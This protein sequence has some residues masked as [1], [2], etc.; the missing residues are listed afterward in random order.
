MTKITRT[1]TAKDFIVLAINP[2]SRLMDEVEVTV[3]EPNSKSIN[4]QLNEA[5]GLESNGTYV[6]F[7][8]LSESEPYEVKL[9]I[10]LAAALS[11]GTIEKIKKDE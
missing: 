11:V 3:I 10:D 5:V 1:C 9:T 8:V 2:D 7:Q 6:F 4:E